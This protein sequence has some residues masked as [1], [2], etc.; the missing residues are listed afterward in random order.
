MIA[1]LVDTVAIQTDAIQLAFKTAATELQT[2]YAH[3]YGDAYR[4]EDLEQALHNWLE[5]SLE[6][7]VEDVLFHTIEGDRSYAFNRSAFELQM[8]RLQPIEEQTAIAAEQVAA[9]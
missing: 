6:S 3:E 8:Q 9:A 4:I 5:L 7:L 1:P 2:H